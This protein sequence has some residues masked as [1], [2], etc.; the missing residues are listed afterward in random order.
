MS[1]R[2]CDRSDERGMLLIEALAD[3]ACEPELAAA[4]TTKKLP[5]CGVV[6]C[7]LSAGGSLTR[8]AV[9][10]LP[11]GS[12]PLAVKPKSKTT[13]KGAAPKPSGLFECDSVR[14]CLR[15]CCCAISSGVP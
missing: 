15:I 6:V 11:V 5:N 3:G 2:T 7:T 9:G 1:T 4:L 14:R 12:K 13:T 8:V 10:Y